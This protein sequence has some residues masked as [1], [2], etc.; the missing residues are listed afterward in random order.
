MGADA[1]GCGS[2][3]HCCGW[4]YNIPVLAERMKTQPK[5]GFQGAHI[6]LH[7]D[8]S[9][10]MI[11]GREDLGDTVDSANLLEEFRGKVLSVVREKYY[12]NP[13][14]TDPLRLQQKRSPTGC[15][16]PQVLPTG[17]D[18]QSL[19]GCGHC[20][21]GWAIG[22]RKGRR[23]AAQ[24]YADGEVESLS[25]IRGVSICKAKSTPWHKGPN[26][27]AHSGPPIPRSQARISLGDSEVIRII[28]Q[29]VRVSPTAS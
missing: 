5:R 24:G 8:V 6:G 14:A 12:R 13:P 9:T 4:E 15:G 17:C 10:T 23:P 29:N 19:S 21:C 7:H 1:V 28:P 20:S 11:R 27:L 25:K 16:V 18:D 2:V 3:G 22:G 26:I